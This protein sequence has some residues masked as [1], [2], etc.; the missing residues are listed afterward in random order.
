MQHRSKVRSVYVLPSE[1]DDTID[2]FELTLRLMAN[3]IYTGI[4]EQG[5]I[6]RAVGSGQYI[7]ESSRVDHAR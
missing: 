1:D 4:N 6:I 5:D 3:A 7:V 2:D